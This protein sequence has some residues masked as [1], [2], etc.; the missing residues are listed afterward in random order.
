MDRLN[1]ALASFRCDLDKDIETF[2]HEKAIN[3]LERGWCSVYLIVDEAE[4]DIGHIKIDAYFTLSHKSLIPLQASKSSIKATS[5]FKDAQS[6][7]FVL[8]GQLGK[9]K[10]I[11]GDSAVLSADI[12]GSDIL[13]YAFEIIRASNSLI[14]C[15][16]ALVECSSDE[17]VQ[18][19]YK[20]NGFK[21]FQVDGI[22]Y[23]FYK[24][25]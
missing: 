15:R 3:F 25:I 8:I 18:S 1:D 21:Y 2:L 22:H 19:F 6:I 12:S 20:N 11:D 4:F 16:C 9:Y 24:E 13:N 17:N 14:P 10:Q 5:G 7:H 23:Q